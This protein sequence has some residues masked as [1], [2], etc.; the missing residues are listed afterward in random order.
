[1]AITIVQQVTGPYTVNGAPCPFDLP[2]APTPG[3][4]LIWVYRAS[5]G[6][7]LAQPDKTL[8]GEAPDATRNTL[9]YFR[10]V[11]SGDGT[12]WELNTDSAT[13]SGEGYLWEVSGLMSSG[14]V[15]R[16]S[17]G[18]ASSSTSVQTG[19]TGTLAQDDE[20][21]ITAAGLGGTSGGGQ[22][23]DSGFTMRDVANHDRMII[24][25]KIVS[26]TDAI[27]ATHSWTTSRRNNALIATFK[28]APDA[29][30][31]PDWNVYDQATD[32]WVSHTPTLL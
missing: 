11:Q 14:V 28:A 16:F 7:M 19:S 15:D 10:L 13:N 27:N 2:S 8:V 6:T 20:F 3:N 12:H 21:V 1:M 5:S 25:D 30:A 32:T 24:G 29:P 9:C 23:I 31:A 4:H 22:N 17:A 26:S 18:V